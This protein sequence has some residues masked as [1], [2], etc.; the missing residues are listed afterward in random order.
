M[1]GMLV[2]LEPFLGHVRKSKLGESLWT[3]EENKSS[4]AIAMAA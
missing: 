4:A 3:Q 2:H 1:F